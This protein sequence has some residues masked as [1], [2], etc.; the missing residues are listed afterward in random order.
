[1]GEEQQRIGGMHHVGIPVRSLEQACAWY[2]DVFGL[3][4]MLLDLAEGPALSRTVELE[5][6]RL[7]SAFVSLGNT[8]IE[9]LEYEHPIGEDFSLRN[10]DVGA[11]HVCVEVDDIHDAHERM[12]ARGVAFSSPPVRLSGALEGNWCCY[13]RGHDGLQFELWQ[14]PG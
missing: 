11:A 4:P 7:R 5:D 6:A 3:E 9:L 10:C 13:F 14:R 12:R 1:V 2:R 8:I